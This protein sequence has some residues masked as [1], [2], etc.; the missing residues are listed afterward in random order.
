MNEENSMIVGEN[1]E[2]REISWFDF[3]NVISSRKFIHSGK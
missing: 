3:Q 1:L 2:P